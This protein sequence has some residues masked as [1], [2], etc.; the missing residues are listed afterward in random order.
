MAVTLGSSLP[1]MSLGGTHQV[2]AKLGVWSHLGGTV[3]FS[4]SPS[5]LFAVFS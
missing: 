5:P 4:E 3:V 1:T 2:S